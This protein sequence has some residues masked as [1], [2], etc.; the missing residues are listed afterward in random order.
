MK[1]IEPGQKSMIKSIFSRKA[2]ISKRFVRAFSAAALIIAC[3]AG[4]AIPRHAVAQAAQQHSQSMWVTV[5]RYEGIP[6]PG[7]AARLVGE[8]FIPMISKIPGFIEYFFVD[9]G[10][11]VMVST[12]VFKTSAGEEES[13]MK[14]RQWIL[15]NPE[16][17][18]ALPNPPQITAGK[19][20]GYKGK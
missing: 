13:T 8:S 2:M 3:I 18:A 4:L 17:T 12:S 1:I 11:G 15:N 19:V 5:R 14:A 7:K 9:A 20:V 16:A 6:D 10:N